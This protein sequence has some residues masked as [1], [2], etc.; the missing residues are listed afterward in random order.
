M[1]HQRVG[2]SRCFAP[3]PLLQ[4]G[5]KSMPKIA[6]T[7]F[8]K[9]FRQIEAAVLQFHFGRL[10]HRHQ[11]PRLSCGRLPIIAP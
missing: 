3:E 6:R 7:L 1:A 2:Y 8:E 4:P 11:F 5:A 10:D 9:S